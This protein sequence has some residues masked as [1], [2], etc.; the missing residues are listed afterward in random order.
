MAVLGRVGVALLVSLDE[1]LHQFKALFRF[2]LPQLF[3]K[4]VIEFSRVHL[5]QEVLGCLAVI[6][7]WHILLQSMEIRKLSNVS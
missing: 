1:L 5:P 3:K 7:C 2:K 4:V 6:M